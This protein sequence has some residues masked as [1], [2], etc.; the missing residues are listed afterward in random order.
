M[1]VILIGKV[2]EALHKQALAQNGDGFSVYTKELGLV[3][4]PTK[5]DVKKA[6]NNF[7]IWHYRIA[8]SG[9][10][11][12][13]NIHPFPICDNRYL[14][15]HNGVLGNG[16]GDKSDTRALADL[17]Q[18]VDI[19]TAN[20]VIESLSLGN[21]FAIVSAEDPTSFRLF[22]DWIAEAGVVMSHKMYDP[23]YYKRGGNFNGLQRS[24]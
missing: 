17:L 24:F 19:R 12:T 21:R 8:T 23:R 9:V 10:V 5:A 1:C 16:L 15:Y 20:S 11:D 3:K 7:G 2:T 6:L 13:T 18:E 14:L 22:G 4:A